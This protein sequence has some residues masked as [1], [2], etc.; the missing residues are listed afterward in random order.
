[1]VRYTLAVVMATAGLSQGFQI[2]TPGAQ[3]SLGRNHRGLEA[4]AV[5][6][7]VPTKLSV[8][9]TTTEDEEETMSGAMMD[10]TGIAFSVRFMI[11]IFVVLLIE[12]TVDT[13]T[14]TPLFLLW[15]CRVSRAKPFHCVPTI[16][17]RLQLSGVS[18]RRIAS[19]PKLQSLCHTSLYP[20]L[21]PPCVPLLGSACSKWQTRPIS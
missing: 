16:S 6:N 14:H 7:D 1:M 4:V 2:P 13:D 17:Q 5:G 20:Q 10:L 12:C 21:Q 15:H 11:R 18:F 9:P 3:T 8:P 19:N